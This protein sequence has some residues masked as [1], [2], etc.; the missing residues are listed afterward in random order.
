MKKII[1]VILLLSYFSIFS[2]NVNAENNNNIFEIDTNTD[3]NETNYD[4]LNISQFSCNEDNI[5]VISNVDENR[6]DIY[7]DQGVWIASGSNIK[8]V[9]IPNELLI[10]KNETINYVYNGFSPLGI[11][12]DYDKWGSWQQSP[13]VRLTVNFSGSSIA[14]SVLKSMFIAA[15]KQKNVTISDMAVSYLVGKIVSSMTNNLVVSLKG[16]YS[17]N[18]YCSI[19]RK[20]R[21]NRYYDSGAVMTYGTAVAQWLSSPW[22]YG[23]YPDACRYLTQLY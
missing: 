18:T 6:V 16:D 10:V 8:S 9:G 22:T 17:Y 19:L 7:D 13:I 12:D 14:E 21:L 15:L 23:V 1:I 5:Y 4:L 3:Y 11:A 2:S 20:E